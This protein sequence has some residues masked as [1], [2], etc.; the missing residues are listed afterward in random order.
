MTIAKYFRRILKF[1]ILFLFVYHST[2]ILTS[3]K[4]KPSCDCDS[5]AHRQD[6]EIF[7]YYAFQKGSWWKFRKYPDTTVMDTFYVVD[8]DESYNGSGCTD[9]LEPGLDFCEGTWRVKFSHTNELEFPH[10]NLSNITEIII[11]FGP[12]NYEWFLDFNTQTSAYTS[13]D[14]KYSLNRNDFRIYRLMDTLDINIAGKIYKNVRHV[15]CSD[16]VIISDFLKNTITQTW[17]AKDI[18]LIKY[19]LNSGVSW[20]L[21]DFKVIK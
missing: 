13:G 21:M 1:G 5:I 8:R 9:K 17:W 15:G 11:G 4:K 19:E 12:P 20:E 2:Q 7:K 14:G 6:P 10:S 18:G 3:C 16:S